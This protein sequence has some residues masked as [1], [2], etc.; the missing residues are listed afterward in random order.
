MLSLLVH[1]RVGNGASV[2]GFLLIGI[3]SISRVFNAC[4]ID[5][6]RIVVSKLPEIKSSPERRS[7]TTEP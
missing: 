7:V 2:P 4:E 3:T 1:Y 6:C 5:H